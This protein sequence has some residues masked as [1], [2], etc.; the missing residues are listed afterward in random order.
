[1]EL[2]FI[3]HNLELNQIH[4]KL[5]NNP[6]ANLTNMSSNKKDKSRSLSAPFKKLLKRV[7]SRSSSPVPIDQSDSNL[8][9]NLSRESKLVA[10][11]APP[12]HSTSSPALSGAA[13]QQSICPSKTL[14]SGSGQKAE[15]LGE[16]HPSDGGIPAAPTITITGTQYS[17]RTSFENRGDSN[18]EKADEGAGA[19]VLE[20]P[21]TDQATALAY[22]GLKEG[23]RLV[24]R[25]TDAFPFVKSAMQ[26]FL[27]VFERYDAVTGVPDDLADLKEKLDALASI[28]Q[29]NEVLAIRD[30]LSGLARTFEEKIKIIGAKLERTVGVRII[31]STKDV[32]FLSREIRSLTFAIEIVMMDVNLKTHGMVSDLHHI[33]LLDKLKYVEGAGFDHEDRQGCANGTRMLLLAD[34]LTWAT[35]LKSELV[36]WLNGM[37]GTGKSA[38]AETFCNLLAGKGILGSSFFCSRKTSDRR[39]VNLIFPSLELVRVLQNCLDPTGMDLEKQFKTLLIEP[40]RI[41]F[42]RHSGCIVLV[43]DALDECEDQQ[44]AEKFLKIILREKSSGVLRFFV[45]S[46]PET[47]IRKGFSTGVYAGVRLQDIE[48]HIVKAD[49]RVYLLAAFEGIDDLQSEYDGPWPPVELDTIV[50][51]SGNLF[52]YA[53]TA[54][55]YISDERGD[56]IERLRKY[57]SIAP[58]SNAVEAIDEVYLFILRDTFHQLDNDEQQ[59]VQLCLQTVVCAFEPLSVAM[60][61]VL[62]GM[63]V[64]QVRRAFASLHSVV[65]MPEDKMN[66]LKIVL[67]HA[68]FPDYLTIIQPNLVPEIVA[69]KI[70]QFFLQKFLYWLE[71]LSVTN[72]AQEFAT[73]ISKHLVAIKLS[74]PH[75]YLSAL[76]WVALNSFLGQ[77][78]LSKFSHLPKIIDSKEP[79]AWE[80]LVIQLHGHTDWVNT[81]AYSPDGKHLASGSG[82]ETI[83]IWNAETGQQTLQINIEKMNAIFDIALSSDGQ[84]IISGS[85][86]DIVQIWDANTGLEAFPPLE[87]HTAVVFTVA[88]SADKKYLASGSDDN[89]VRFWDFQTK[90]LLF[91]GEHQDTVNYVEFSPTSKFLASASDDG[92]IKIWSMETYKEV[93]TLKGHTDSV[94]ILSYSQDGNY[95]VS[96]GDDK[97]IRVWN[98]K[99]GKQKFKAMKGHEESVNAVCFSPDQKIIASA[100]DDFTIRFWDAETGKAA[101]QTLK[102][103]DDEVNCIAYSHS[104]KYFASGSSDKRV[105]VWEGQFIVSGSDDDTVRIWDANTGEPKLKPLL[106]HD[107]AVVSVAISSDE[108]YIASGSSDMTVRLWDFYTGKQTASS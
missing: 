93:K 40:A 73:F 72:Q 80:P 85:S 81:I 105:I 27:E 16:N 92:N 8:S 19:S 42:A 97:T 3:E 61:S 45:T 21:S 38:V 52:I 39:K 89:T 94:L 106:G 29:E 46:R 7:S 26:G 22:E 76:P 49:I 70:E 41:A 108:K 86:N 51:N 18:K 102:N 99:T 64:L 103:H 48:A 56:P 90:A 44:A 57:A 87:G 31:E 53:A 55:K 34:L 54:V 2:E 79:D 91:K 59:R 98:T 12:V 20:E 32:E 68:S 28:L 17:A 65:Q 9:M 35:E 23:L 104:G 60:Y 83:R 13:R 66:D 78:F 30:C 10:M 75:I 25:C 5:P 58:P 50:E 88:T 33:A 74:A 62:L 67:Y 63:S 36:F 100:S 77:N 6:L 71:V 43:V 69:I 95:L 24:I 37:A 15:G 96:S 1:M 107:D 82:D 4:S 14:G 47:K 11:P 84:Y 101:G